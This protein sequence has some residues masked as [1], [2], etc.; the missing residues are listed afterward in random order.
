MSSHVH[1]SFTIGPVQGFVSQARRTRDLWAGSWLLSYLAETALAAAENAG[2]LAI[3]P[4]RADSDRGN[5]TSTRTVVGG[6]PN[7]FEMTF[8]TKEAAQEAAQ[9]ATTAF[10]AAWNRIADAVWGKYVAEAASQEGNGTQS[11]WN[12]QVENF[13]ELSWVVGI[14]V[15]GE[16][17]LGGLAAARK[18]YRNVPANDE[19]G[20]KCSLTGSLQELS[21]HY[22]KGSGDRQKA[23]WAAVSGKTGAHD[24]RESEKL[25]AVSLIK[26]LFPRVIRGAI[27]GGVCE[28]LT[29][30]ESWPSLA[31]FSAL[32]WLRKLEKRVQEEAEAY[33]E[34]AHAAKATGNSDGIGFGEL[35]AAKDAGIPWVKIDGAA[36]FKSALR[37]NEWN[38][39]PDA[40]RGLQQELN[41][42]YQKVPDG[43]VPFYA[44]LLMDGDL[45]GK[46][47]GL[48]QAPQKLSECL[49]KFAGQVDGIVR[50]H[51]GCTIY[52]GGDDVLAI[53]PAQEAFEAAKKLAKAYQQ[54][55]GET[56]AQAQATLS[57]AIV[58]AHW[59][60]PMQ[61]VLGTAHRLLDSVAK[62]QTGRDAL[63]IGIL[64]GSGLNAVWSAPW[65][66]IR[67][68]AKFPC[69]ES[70]FVHFGGDDT[71]QD[72]ATFNASY[73]YNLRTLYSRLFSAMDEGAGVFGEVDMDADILTDIAHAEYR[74]RMSSQERSAM[75]PDET[76]KHIEKLM[77]LS[78]RWTHDA[79]TNRSTGNIRTF[80]FDGW[81]VVRFMK[82]VEEGKVGDHE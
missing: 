68:E 48:L 21:G 60:Y 6:V 10:R 17:T 27:G 50:S 76:R 14:P 54:S 65:Q 67:G 77:A 75:P 59:R 2:G 35:R 34:K 38:I 45:M 9:A 37:N 32:P 61:R 26:R 30:Q 16:Q 39:R 74:R 64:Q 80:G 73:L 79:N 72:A 22:A 78:R 70:M 41:A 57:G 13:W 3:I 11:I 4:A 31:F 5:V 36:W 49:G 12:R 7:R 1:L 71:A 63:A 52:A 18:A 81:R 44:M 28:E 40:I 82:Q 69:L 53:L 15:P 56:E 55:F 24:L 62:D 58:Y 23:F 25:C 46:L 42:L 8:D 51:D 43:P 47:L 33:I 20:V 19:L 29:Q 66:F